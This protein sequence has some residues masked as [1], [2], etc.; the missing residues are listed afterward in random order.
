MKKKYYFKVTERKAYDGR[1][2]PDYTSGTFKSKRKAEKAFYDFEALPNVS[3]G[4]SAT[5]II[6]RKHET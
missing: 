1:V 2:F 5:Y 4:G 6:G 3:C